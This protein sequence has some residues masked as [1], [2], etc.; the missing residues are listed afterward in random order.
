M[1]DQFKVSHSQESWKIRKQ[2]IRKT[3][4]NDQLEMSQNIWQETKDRFVVSTATNGS[5][6]KLHQCTKPLIAALFPVA[7]YSFLPLMKS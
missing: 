6:N 2:K 7:F 1:K 3:T 5:Q 4:G